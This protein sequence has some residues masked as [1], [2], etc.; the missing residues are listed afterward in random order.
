LNTGAGKEKTESSGICDNSSTNGIII[1]VDYQIVT[2]LK[3]YKK[4]EIIF[5]DD[6]STLADSPSVRQALNRLTRQGIILRLA[7]GIYY[8]PVVHPSLGVMMPGLDD[9]AHAIARR[10]RAKIVPSGALALNK[11]GL[12]TQVPVKVVYLTNGSPRTVRIGTGSIKFKI[13]SPKTFAV[14]S[15]VNMLVIQALREIGKE[16]ITSEIT[17]HLMTILKKVDPKLIVHDMRMAP[18]WISKIMKQALK[19]EMK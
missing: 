13:T 2:R 18:E 1:S 3:N 19:G 11:L 4:G 9:I 17:D 16:Y 14:K 8:F 15:E 6:F 5:F 10:D 12:S 7:Q